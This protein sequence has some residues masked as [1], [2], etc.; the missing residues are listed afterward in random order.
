MPYTYFPSPPS[1]TS[2]A[3]LLCMLYNKISNDVIY[4]IYRRCRPCFKVEMPVVNSYYD[5]NLRAFENIIDG[6]CDVYPDRYEGYDKFDITYIVTRFMNMNEARYLYSRYNKKIL[7]DDEGR[8]YETE[9][10]RGSYL[11]RRRGKDPISYSYILYE[12]DRFYFIK[13]EL[14]FEIQQP[15]NIGIPHILPII[16]LGVI[17][18]F[19]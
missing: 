3:M 17:Y 1:Q 2:D 6:L 7:Q 15:E 10:D 14:E 18:F 16:L 9:E 11:M 13:N 12:N 19:Y 4:E 8:K 5:P